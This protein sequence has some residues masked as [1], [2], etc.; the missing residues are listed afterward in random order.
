[1]VRTSN[2]LIPPYS[3][4]PSVLAM[5]P[6]ERIDAAVA[7]A[8]AR[9]GPSHD[10][11]LLGAPISA[12]GGVG[13]ARVCELEAHLG[14]ALPAEYRCFVERHGWLLLHDGLQVAGAMPPEQ[15][16]GE[17][18]PWLSAEHD[19]STEYLVVGALGMFADGDQL[20]IDLGR[21]DRELIAYLHDRGPAF[22]P[23]AESFSL[24]L[25][26]LMTEFAPMLLE[27]ID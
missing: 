8:H 22:E 23:I 3:P 21:P 26:R 6:S 17:G 9:F 19:A 1:M 13:E 2:R 7:L 20:V 16:V 11:E 15:I 14:R 10:E 24:G 25:Y 5:S 12:A 27:E 18:V 4:E